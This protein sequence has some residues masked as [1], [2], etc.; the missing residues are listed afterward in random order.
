MAFQMLII[1]LAGVIGGYKLDVWLH[2]KPLLTIILSI[3]SV[4]LAI[5]YFT[6][7]LMKK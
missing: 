2:T 6:R 1:I 3:F 5:Y 7:D 4:F